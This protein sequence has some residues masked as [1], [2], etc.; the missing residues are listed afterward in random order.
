[1]EILESL[2][3]WFG[4][5]Y[6]FL[7][8]AAIGSFLNVCIYRI[9]KGES[10]IH[11]RSRCPSCHTPIA[12][13]DNIPLISWL[14]LRGR[15][16]HCREPISPRYFLVEW[17]TA[18]IFV[19]LFIEHRWHAGF[20]ISALL[21]SL[22]IALMFIDWDYQILPDGLTV[23]GIII[24]MVLIPVNPFVRWYDALAGL[25]IGLGLPL[26]LIWFYWLWRREEG[27]GLGDVKLLGMIGVFLGVRRLFFVILLGAILGLIGGLILWIRSHRTG[28]FA[29]QAIPFGTF[30]CL[31][32]LITLLFGERFIQWYDAWSVRVFSRF[33]LK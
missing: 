22:C 21:A 12:W 4:V 19:F 25:L 14:F 33:L 2:P 8:G 30:L 31:A 13:Y 10:I 1:M 3:S 9:P 29:R 7:M 26:I 20:F 5:I 23:S 28:S 11:P 27:M 18:L 15:C 24:G 32:T 6:W 16:R 17:I